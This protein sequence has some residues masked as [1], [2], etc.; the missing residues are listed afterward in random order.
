M[1]LAALL[2]ACA[3]PGAAA[4]ADI[5]VLSAAAVAPGLVKLAEQ[6]RKDT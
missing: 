5:K 3:L 1:R 2:V 4:A 6:Y